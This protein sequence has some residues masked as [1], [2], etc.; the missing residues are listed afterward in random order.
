MLLLAAAL[1][2]AILYKTYQSNLK[3]VNSSK[4]VI[5]ITI[6]PG[7]TNA[8]IADLLAAKK[9]IRSDWTFEWYLRTHPVNGGLQAGTFDLSADKTVPEI[10]TILTTGVVAVDEPVTILP[11]KRLDQVRVAL[12]EKAGFSPLE[13]DAALEPT[14]YRDHP[15]LAGKPP[16]A[17]LE[18]YL[19]PETFHK[20]ANTSAKDIIRLSLDEMN[21]YLTPEIRAAFDSQG[22][23][24]YQAV[25][26][27]SIVEREL[28]K[29][30]D[31][32]QAA[33]VF[34]KRLA[35]GMRL[36]SNATDDYAA[37]DAAYD[38]YKIAGLP[39]GPISNIS[40]SS[41]RAAAFPSQTD[42]LYFVSGDGEFSGITYFSKTLAEHQQSTIKHCSQCVR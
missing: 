11:G 2:S 17:S 7:S 14:Q 22:L 40:Q 42:W 12:I 18:G 13:V 30:E 34:Y 23:T 5:T 8:Q 20:T 41:L 21:L 19:Y 38:T 1:G 37:I 26:L 4:A 32:A 36:E 24:P 29:P 31:R 6:A 15:A 3:P 10:I 35:G 25:T 33:Q 27:A 28:S 39:P 9:I 16:A